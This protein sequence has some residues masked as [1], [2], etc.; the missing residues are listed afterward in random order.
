M[1]AE[2]NFLLKNANKRFQIDAKTSVFL[3]YS[4]R[5]NINTKI[6]RFRRN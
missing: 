1:K 6:L 4:L 5:S 3:C 2:N